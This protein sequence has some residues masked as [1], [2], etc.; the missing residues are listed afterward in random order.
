MSEIEKEKSIEKEKKKEWNKT[1]YEKNK[2]WYNEK[3]KCEI[4]GGEYHR[5][6]KTKHN[7]LKKHINAIEKK[8][9]EEEIAELKNK[10][11]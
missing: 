8:K 5:S 6:G 1:Y 11:I 10:L 2:E 4:C 3:L 9:M 7:S